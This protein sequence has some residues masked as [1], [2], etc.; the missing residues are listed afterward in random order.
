MNPHATPMP[1]RPMPRPLMFAFVGG[2]PR[3]P[4]PPHPQ[5]AKAGLAVAA[6]TRNANRVIAIIES[7][8]MGF[9]RVVHTHGPSYRNPTLDRTEKAL[10][11][12]CFPAIRPA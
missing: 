1:A 6:S 9:L 7:R 3:R 2:P 11:P 12:Q 5:S 10:R 8:V 4:P